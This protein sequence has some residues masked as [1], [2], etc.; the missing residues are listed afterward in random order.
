V[1]SSRSSSSRAVSRRTGVARALSKL[2]VAS[3]SVAARWVAAGRVTV[4][5]RVVRDPETPVVPDRDRLALDGAAVQAEARRYLMLNKPRGLVTTRRDERGRDTVYRCLDAGAQGLSPVG[6]LDKASEGLLL[7]SNDGIWAQRL[8]DPASHLPKVYHVQIDRGADDGLL[9]ALRRGVQLEE[10][11]R[12]QVSQ[13][14]R[15]REGEKNSWLEIVLHEG[16]NRHIRRLL[17]ALDVGVK[18][19]VRVAIG[20]LNLGALAKGRSRDL[21][22]AELK[23][24]AAAL[25]AGPEPRPIS[26]PPL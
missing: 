4:N 5:G 25:E 8:L 11:E 6:R 18:R 1:A 10:D 22:A 17:D 24:V 14:R 20:P 3:R 19:L 9:E 15:L 13:A 26:K 12:L 7:F 21:T 16:R 2:G 23:A